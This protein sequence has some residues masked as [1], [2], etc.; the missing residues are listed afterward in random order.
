MNRLATG[1]AAIGLLAL[2]GLAGGAL[3]SGTI[4]GSSA[5]VRGAV[6]LAH[7]YHR[8]CQP[9]PRGWWHRNAILGGF[10]VACILR[11]G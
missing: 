8:A 9:G 10:P 3:A 1:V 11:R 5:E 6:T 2:S 4:E 7:G